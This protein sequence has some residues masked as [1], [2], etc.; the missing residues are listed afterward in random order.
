MYDYAAA[1][2]RNPVAWA[3]HSER[4]VRIHEMLRVLGPRLDPLKL[5]EYRGKIVEATRTASRLNPTS[6]ELHARLAH[7][8]ADIMMFGD[9]VTE[10]N[11]ALQARPHHASRRQE[12]ARALRRQLEDLI[13][14]WKASAE[15]MPAMTTPP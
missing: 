13:P 2:P 6:S 1:P 9:A 14:K 15:K 11:E 4:A 7:A 3:I 10:A 8:S 12:V 5:T